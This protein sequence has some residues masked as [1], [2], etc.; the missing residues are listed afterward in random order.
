MLIHYI[1]TCRFSRIFNILEK[2][3]PEPKASR[4]D[5]FSAIHDAE[6]GSRSR[7]YAAK[8]LPI[9]KYAAIQSSEET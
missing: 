3:Q 2:Q 4:S 1:P 6:L 8:L 7:S 5:I 9:T